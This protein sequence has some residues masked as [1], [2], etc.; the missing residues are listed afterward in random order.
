M[1]SASV[2][3]EMIEAKLVFPVP[4]GPVKIIEVKQSF[5]IERR[6][7]TPPLNAPPKKLKII[8]PQLLPKARHVGDQI[9]TFLEFIWLFAIWLFAIWLFGYQ[10]L[11][12]PNPQFAKEISTKKFYLTKKNLAKIAVFLKIKVENF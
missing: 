9:E 12:S 1:K 7:K 8:W 11:S 10:I 2:C 5:S 3:F 6:R 4:G